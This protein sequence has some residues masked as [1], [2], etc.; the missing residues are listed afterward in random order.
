MSEKYA[1]VAVGVLACLLVYKIFRQKKEKIKFFLPYM[2]VG[3]YPFV[4]YFILKN[5]SYI[6]SFFT[7]REFTI[8]LYA[9]L[10]SIVSWDTFAAGGREKYV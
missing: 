2:I 3:A 8:A 6:H 4:W 7:Y 1:W 10:V 5:H 9:C